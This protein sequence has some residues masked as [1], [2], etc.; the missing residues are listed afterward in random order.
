[1]TQFDNSQHRVP[2][3]TSQKLTDAE[4][5]HASDLV[6]S[7]LMHAGVLGGKFTKGAVAPVNTSLIWLDTSTRPAKVK[8]YNGTAW[9]Q[10]LFEDIWVDGNALSLSG[11]TVNGPVTVSHLESTG[12]VQT[13][14]FTPATLPPAGAYRGGFGYCETMTGA[15]PAEGLVY[16]DGVNWRKV[17]NDL[18]VA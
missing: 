17:A 8:R 4:L 16:C 3:T 11:G 14:V 18:I 1:M 7:A 2:F 15:G 5:L 13:S 9:V 10:A 6:L 12:I